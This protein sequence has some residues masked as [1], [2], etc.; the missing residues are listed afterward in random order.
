MATL[1]EIR[2][3]ADAKLAEFWPI[4]Q[5]KQNNYFNKHG[6]YFQL[7]ASPEVIVID[8]TDSVYT[9]LHPSDEAYEIDVN[10]SFSS[11][12]PFTIE[13]HEWG[14][15][16]GYGYKAIVTVQLLDGRVFSRNRDSNQIDSG[17]FEVNKQ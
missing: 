8:G 14:G 15:V 1:Q 5:T 6:K 4:L 11:T 9:V 17:W 13:V 2:T 3:K 16:D 10:F 7:L 12:V